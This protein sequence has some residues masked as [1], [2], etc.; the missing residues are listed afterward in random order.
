MIKDGLPSIPEPQPRSASEL[1]FQVDAQWVEHD[2]LGRQALQFTQPPDVLA[3]DEHVQSQAELLIGLP[4]QLES[5]RSRQVRVPKEIMDIALT[6]AREASDSLHDWQNGVGTPFGIKSLLY[7][8]G[9]RNGE[10]DDLA[11]LAARYVSVR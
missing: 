7:Q 5:L 4:A 11:L 8:P 6:L 2:N 3:S 1:L 10:A 9:R